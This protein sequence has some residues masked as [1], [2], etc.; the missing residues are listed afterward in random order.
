MAY[1]KMYANGYTFA[2]NEITGTIIATRELQTTM[3]ERN[4]SVMAKTGVI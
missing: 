4:Q 1:E 3:A 2:V